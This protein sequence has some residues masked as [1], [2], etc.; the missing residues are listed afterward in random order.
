MPLILVIGKKG[1]IKEFNVND[2]NHLHATLVSKVEVNYK[3]HYTF[4]VSLENSVYSISV[5]GKIKGKALEENKYEFPPPLD[6]TLFFGNCVLV[7]RKVEHGVENNIVHL[8]I[9]QWNDVYEHLFGGFSDI[10]SE[11]D[12]ESEIILNPKQLSEGYK[13]DGFVVDDNESVDDDIED[14]DDDDNDDNDDDADNDDDDVVAN[15]SEDEYNTKRK[16]NKLLIPKLIKKDKKTKK[17]SE[18]YLDCT[19]EL[20][21]EDYFT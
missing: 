10:C 8:T 18:V 5:Y 9:K 7:N 2:S 13:K 1:V 19:S 14:I 17:K 12:D 4:H 21:A 16:V 6:N 3:A 15:N 11:S 20:K